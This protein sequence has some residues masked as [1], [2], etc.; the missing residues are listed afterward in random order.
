MASAHKRLVDAGYVDKNMLVQPDDD[1]DEEQ[2]KVTTSK[3]F[4]RNFYTKDCKNY[5]YV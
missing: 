2:T 3:L 1:N 5:K 4:S